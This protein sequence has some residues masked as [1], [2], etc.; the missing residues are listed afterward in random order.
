M[1]LVRLLA[2]RHLRMRPLRAVLAM[3]AVAAGSAM[4]V[5]V[6]VVQSSSATSVTEFARSLS[7]PTELRVV[8]PIRRGG[9]EPSVVAA[10]EDTDGVA[11]AIPMVQGV[12]LLDEPGRAGTSTGADDRSTDD[13]VTVLGVDCRVEALVGP[14]G[15]TPDAWSTTATG[16]SPSGPGSTP[17]PRCAPRA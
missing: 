4:A 12:S 6:F 3:L 16:R 10:V 17:R 5:S 2:L 8:G 11:L 9:L 14:L 1:R 7:G 13:A 15:C